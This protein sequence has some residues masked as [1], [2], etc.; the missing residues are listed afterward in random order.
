MDFNL[1]WHSLRELNSFSILL[2]LLLAVIC[3][4]VIGIERGV[5]RQPAGF[6]THILVCTGGCLATLTG[7][8]VF[9]YLDTSAD[10]TRLGA[11][12]ISGIGFLGMGT[13]IVTGNNRVKGLT[14]AAG[15]WASACIGLT[16]GIGFYE[17]AIGGTIIVVLAITVMRK[18]D[19]YFYAKIPVVDLYIELEDITKV[20][21]LLEN[22]QQ[23]GMK[24]AFMELEKPKS[25]HPNAI[26]LTLTVK[27]LRRKDP[28]D[29]PTKIA[30]FPGVLFLE[31][32]L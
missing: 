6:R 16:I 10:P 29:M 22:I 4:G 13:I 18:V 3:A 14:T 20:H 5:R 17:A 15:L 32:I 24:V 31:E 19:G 2:R 21:T 1:I 26:G 9:Q 8:Y 12:V 25:Q 11:Q 28:I 7:Q 30:S 27:K 23:H